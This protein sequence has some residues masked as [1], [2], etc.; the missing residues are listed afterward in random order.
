MF[1]AHENLYV[2]KFKKSRR[3]S[4]HQLIQAFFFLDEMCGFVN[5]S[6]ELVQSR[7]PIVE[8]LRLALLLSEVDNAR[9]PVDFDLQSCVV[10]QLSEKFFRLQFIE[11]EKLSHATASDASVVVGD[12]ADVLGET[13]IK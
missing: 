10:D 13:K 12:N 2:M 8:N 6:H 5:A 11:I 9:W 3:N 7:R 4:G 1:L